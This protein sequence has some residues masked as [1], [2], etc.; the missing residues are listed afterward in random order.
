MWAD[1]ELVWRRTTRGRLGRCNHCAALL[2]YRN[3]LDS[4]DGGNGDGWGS[5]A[6]TL[7]GD[8]GMSYGFTVDGESLAP[9]SPRGGGGTGAAVTPRVG[10]VG[11]TGEDDSAISAGWISSFSNKKGVFR[12]NKDGKKM[13]YTPATSGEGESTS[14]SRTVSRRRSG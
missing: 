11:G 3:L 5:L 6:R 14:A 4:I 12:W 7:L 2:L 10:I 8:D 9:A 13:V 1:L